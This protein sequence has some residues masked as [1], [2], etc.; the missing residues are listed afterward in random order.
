[1]EGDDF[2]SSSPAVSE[3]AGPQPS[4]LSED[5]NKRRRLNDGTPQR[6][7]VDD[8]WILDPPRTGAH[9]RPSR[10]QQLSAPPS[11]E[12]AAQ[13]QAGQ[14]V[15]VYMK[16]FVT[17]TE[18]VV[19][20]GPT[21]NMVIGP[22]GTGKSTLVCAICLGLG[23]SPS[24]LGR[25]KETGEFIKNGCREAS[26]EIELKGKPGQPNTIMRRTL[27]KEGNKSTFLI[28][29]ESSNNKKTMEA[30]R[31]FNIQVD[32]LCHFL[33]QDRVVEFS[34]LG[35]VDRLEQTLKATAPDEIFQAY[36]ELKELREQQRKHEGQEQS[37][38]N[39]LQSAQTRQEGQRADVDRM[40]ARAEFKEKIDWLERVKPIV[41]AQ[42][43]K[44][45][46]KEAKETVRALNEQL[47]ECEARLAPSLLEENAKK[48]YVN[49]IATTLQ[50]RARKTKI[51]QQVRQ[52]H[53]K[54]IAV[55]Q[56]KLT[57]L[58]T[59][60]KTLAKTLKN[61]Q[62]DVSKYEEQIRKI[63]DEIARGAPDT[64]IATL[65]TQ[66]RDIERQLETIRRETREINDRRAE[67]AAIKDDRQKRI[68]SIEH[69]LESL[70][71]AA[72]RRGQNLRSNARD[73][74]TAWAEVQ[75]RRSDFKG[76]V[77]GPAVLECTLSDKSYANALETLISEG[78][79]TALT[80]TT[81][82]DFQVL[83]DIVYGQLQLKSV[84]LRSSASNLQDPR[85][86]RNISAE[87]EAALGV[88][89]WA[90]DLLEGPETVLAMLCETSRLHGTAVCNREVDESLKRQI[91]DLDDIANY[92]SP[93]QVYRIRR[94]K[95][96]NQISLTDTALRT[97]K[98]WNEA[99]VDNSGASE[100]RHDL[101]QFKIEMEELDKNAASQRAVLEE[102]EREK[103]RL[104][105]E[106]EPLEEDKV[107]QQTRET[108]WQ[109]LPSRKR[110]CNRSP[111]LQRDLLTTFS[112][113]CSIES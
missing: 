48:A 73:A 19:Y 106:K 75:K 64:D 83:Q 8:S 111:E 15:R 41:K 61:H 84:T 98:Y 85:F 82:E 12:L 99:P 86:G 4:Q 68:R 76:P 70:N 58:T 92:I 46:A 91:R 97:S 65:T 36:E 79:L 31:K 2:E 113:N 107:R 47:R 62:A 54:A 33:P 87:D 105:G 7:N 49:E 102:K 13:F 69:H 90:V 53:E 56:T 1:M 67:A 37:W 109:G 43:V 101:Q 10:A 27:K 23:F 5:S 20:P 39:Q 45:Q 77:Y 50:N 40:R 22:N 44:A 16:N 11:R 30:V 28:N 38:R 63:D 29:G 95:E 72:G 25:A 3:D 104:E 42:E 59:R 103:A 60:K 71:T 51:A 78:D 32:N 57:A 81:K 96:Y 52:R 18:A 100:A 94:R 55:T 88:E 9:G 110:E 14:I 6:E 66:I 93:S 21:L 17:Y 80:V 74:A 35:P 26:I 108:R 34:Q 112:R 89:A 24:L